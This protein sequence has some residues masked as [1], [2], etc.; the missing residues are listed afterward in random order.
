[1]RYRAKQEDRRF[2]DYDLVLAAAEAGLG[3]AVL[4]TPLA[5]S[6]VN[7]DKLVRISRASIPNQ[8]GHYLAMRAGQDHSAVLQVAER[9]RTCAFEL[10]RTAVTW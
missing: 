4:R 5:D 2:E 7:S 3:I 6:Y 9:L 8:H 1:M 10:V